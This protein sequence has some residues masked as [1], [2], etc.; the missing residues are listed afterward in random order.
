MT[1]TPVGPMKSASAQRLFNYWQ[2]L[3]KDRP[4]PERRD[5]EPAAIK[6]LLGDVFILEHDGG[7]DFS[8]RLAGSALCSA[9]CRELK[10]RD[11]RQFWQDGDL[12]AMD[13]TMLAIREDA[14]AAVIGYNGVNARGQTAPYE[15]LLLP[16]RYGGT[17]YPRI[18]GLAAPMDSHYW[19]GTSPILLH[20]ISSMRLIWPDEKPSFMRQAVNDDLIGD[21]DDL[22]VRTSA[23]FGMEA[24]ETLFGDRA[25]ARRR[26]FRVI[27]GGLS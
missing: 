3:R 4:A 11:F 24:R 13:T 20:T 17:D 2:N 7:A 5:I 6:A 15:M 19:I 9:Y 1:Q 8:Y 16:L 18:L 10:G 27:D 23:D 12:E 14:A 21:D 22:L 26:A 25:A